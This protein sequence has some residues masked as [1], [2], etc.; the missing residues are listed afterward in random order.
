MV[1]YSRF[2]QIL[3]YFNFIICLIFT[4]YGYIFPDKIT[5]G[6]LLNTIGSIFMVIASFVML[7]LIG[8][9]CIKLGNLSVNELIIFDAKNIVIYVICGINLVYRLFC[10][11]IGGMENG[12][13][14]TSA[15]LMAGFAIGL[16]LNFSVILITTNFIQSE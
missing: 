2:L 7:I 3:G 6:T 8:A 15:K 16:L 9:F 1:A 11:N 13:S 12:S 10:C 14:F 5:G 4:T